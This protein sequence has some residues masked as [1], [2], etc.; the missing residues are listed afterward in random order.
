[1]LVTFYHV[2][3]TFVVAVVT[4]F[5]F[6]FALWFT[7]HVC[8]HVCDFGVVVA[9]FYV[10]FVVTLIVDICVYVVCCYVLRLICC[11]DLFSSHT[12]CAHVARCHV[13]SI[14]PR[15]FTFGLPRFHI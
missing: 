15:W 14:L 10:D 5:A 3:G 11:W 12:D 2:V 4:L 6:T 7:L 1:M 8:L 13:G 9:L